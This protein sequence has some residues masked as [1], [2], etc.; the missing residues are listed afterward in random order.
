MFANLDEEEEVGYRFEKV[1]F[2]G[3]EGWVVGKP[4]VLCGNARLEQFF[5]KSFLGD[6][7]AVLAPSRGEDPHR[8]AKA[9]SRRWH[10]GRRDD[11]AQRRR[12]ILFSTQVLLHTTDS[13]VLGKAEPPY[14]ENRHGARLVKG[15]DD[16]EHGCHLHDY[17][18]R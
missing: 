12:E 11:S 8:H 9:A 3:G 18:C 4:S 15:R 14:P 16:D 10:G 5:T 17:E 6:D 1:S 2:K 13:G 7:A